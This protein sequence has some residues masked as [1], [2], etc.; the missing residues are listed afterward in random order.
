MGEEEKSP[1]PIYIVSDLVEDI[2]F[3]LPLKPILKFKTV[4]KQWR[5]IIESKSFA[6]RRK[7][8]QKNPKILAVGESRFQAGGDAEVDLVYL[9]CHDATTR[10]SLTCDGLVCIPVP[11]WVNVFNPSTGEFLR[12]PSGP[13][14][15][16]IEL[17]TGK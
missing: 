8:V 16:G 9:Q 7:S 14:H 5:T 15:Y 17:F 4:S 3:R 11:D 10:P 1:N 13:S 12:F 6:E 2:L